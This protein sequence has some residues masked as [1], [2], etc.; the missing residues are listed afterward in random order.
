V[1]KGVVAEEACLLS[2]CGVVTRYATKASIWPDTVTIDVDVVGS[3][4]IS[5]TVKR[6][7]AGAAAS[8]VCVP[9]RRER[10]K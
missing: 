8:S 4:R 10:H 3:E 5:D 6:A 7:Y 2:E 1:G 9:N